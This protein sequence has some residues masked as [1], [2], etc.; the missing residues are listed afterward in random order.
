MSTHN[1]RVITA[2]LLAIGLCSHRADGQNLSASDLL[3]KIAQTYRQ[4]SSFRVVAAKR[5]DFDQN[6][7][8]QPY[9]DPRGIQEGALHESEEVRVTLMVSSSSKVKL[10]LKSDKKE[11]VVVCDGNAVWTLMPAQ[12]KYTE[13]I[14]RSASINTPA[15]VVRIGS[16]DILGDYLLEQYRTML[17]DRFRSTSNY[18]GWIKLESSQ[19]LKAGKDKKECYVLVKQMPG[20]T[21]KQKLWV[22]KTAFI[23]WKSVDTTL[24][25]SDLGVVLQKKV[26]VTLKQLELNPPLDDSNFVFTAPN[27]ARKVNSL[28]VSGSNPF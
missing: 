25:P 8:M 2:F 23:I 16:N 19:T 10:L 12:L 13:S 4:I 7:T 9:V 14:L 26:T 28:K 27:K 3:N 17:D 24:L 22:D 11:V 1:S 20:S 15:H 5:V 6:A 18:E 21:E